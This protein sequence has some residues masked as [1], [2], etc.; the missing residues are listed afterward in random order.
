MRRSPA[1][2]SSTICSGCGQKKLT[3]D[4]GTRVYACEHRD[5]VIDRD[6]NAGV[7]LA[8]WTPPPVST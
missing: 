8:R 4:L 5:L 2:D 3:L 7:N 6:H 1:S